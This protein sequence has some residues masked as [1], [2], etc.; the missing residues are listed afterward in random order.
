MIVFAFQSPIICLYAGTIL[1]GTVNILGHA[2]AFPLMR[3]RWWLIHRKGGSSEIFFAEKTSENLEMKSG[4][5]AFV[6]AEN[7]ALL[8]CLQVMVIPF[9]RN[10][11]MEIPQ[12]IIAL[13][14]ER[15]AIPREMS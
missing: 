10:E 14:V 8:P 13:W 7:L 9:F 15:Y 3:L 2:A 5:S 11:M 1:S 4:V 6:I 12:S